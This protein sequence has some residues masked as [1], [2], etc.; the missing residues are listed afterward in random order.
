MYSKKQFQALRDRMMAVVIV[1][2]EES[3]ELFRFATNIF[4]EGCDPDFVR[5]K[6]NEC[7]KFDYYSYGL[8]YELIFGDPIILPR[9]IDSVFSTVVKWRLDTG[10]REL[11]IVH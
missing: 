9:Y 11:S 1:P 3:N 10:E 7:A 5:R 4:I 2:F 6:I 8:L